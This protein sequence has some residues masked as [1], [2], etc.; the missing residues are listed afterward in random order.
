MSLFITKNDTGPMHIAFCIEDTSNALFS[1]TDPALCGPYGADKAVVIAKKAT[2]VPCVG[3]KCII[4]NVLK[5]ITPQEVIAAAEGLLKTNNKLDEIILNY[6]HRT[7]D[8][9]K[10]CRL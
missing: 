7:N 8:L 10:F 2:C 1:P 4:P 6:R 3:K 5:L 9:K